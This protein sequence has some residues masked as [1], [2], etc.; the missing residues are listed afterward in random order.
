VALSP[1]ACVCRSAAGELL[2]IVRSL[3]RGGSERKRRAARLDTQSPGS[4]APPR[5]RVAAP[6]RCEHRRSCPR[7]RPRPSLL[8]MSPQP[9]A[10]AARSP[11]GSEPCGRQAARHGRAEVTRCCCCR[12]RDRHWGVGGRSRRLPF[13]SRRPEGARPPRPPLP[14]ASGGSP[15]GPG[16]RPG[17]RQS[18]G[19][20]LAAGLGRAERLRLP[21]PGGPSTLGKRLSLPAPGAGTGASR[22]ARALSRRSLGRRE[23]RSPL[24]AARRPEGFTSRSARLSRPPGVARA[25]GAGRLEAGGS[26]LRCA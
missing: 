20:R 7:R 10:V 23:G 24:T 8:P 13:T 4:S 5:G 22:S 15:P 6:A 19:G 16:G 21:Q 12:R 1:G 9:P 3:Q 11:C 14:R 17:R 26:L 2:F 25:C 18:L